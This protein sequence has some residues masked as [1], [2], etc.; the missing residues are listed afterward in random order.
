MA[1]KPAM[2]KA[3]QFDEVFAA[4]RAMLARYVSPKMR[5]VHDKPDNYYVETTFP[6]WKGKPIMFA[7]VRK[8]KAYVSYHLLPLYMNPSLQAKVPKELQKRQ[9]GKACFNFST[10]DKARI[11]DLDKLTREGLECFTK[12]GATNAARPEKK[13]KRAASSK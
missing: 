1:A 3:P 11:T 4:L 5:V 10:V 13:V 6:V 2:K 12:L 7:A 8:G 9:Q